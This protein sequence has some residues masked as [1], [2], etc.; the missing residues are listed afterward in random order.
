MRR[1]ALLTALAMAAPAL[2]QTGPLPPS[3]TDYVYAR[4]LALSA[5]RGLAGDN[6]AIFYNPAAIAG[7]RHLEIDLQGLLA[8][9][10]SD[11]TGT[12]FSFSAVDSTSGP[13]AGGVAYTYP[14]T[15]GYAPAGFFGGLSDLALAFPLGKTFY[16]GGTISYL[17]VAS[18]TVNVSA[19]NV[20][21]GVLWQVAKLVSVG[22]V[23]Y[24]LINTHHPDLTPLALGAGAAVGADKAF[25]LTGDFYREW[26]TSV[27]NVWS[28]GGEAFLF[29]VL[30][31]RGG[32]T[33]DL[34]RKTDWWAGGLGFYTGGFGFDAT[35]K[36]SLGGEGRVLAVGIKIVPNL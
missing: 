15:L 16:V 5:Y 13:V 31:V 6:D 17:A 26:G 28:A 22:A 29:D 21:P 32:W 11:T 34:G 20:T 36:Q 7:R 18:P 19:V 35:Y 33:F 12:F 27:R 2:A 23:G 8:R 24:N 10:G 30:A 25:H 3:P 1:L 14:K 9:D 4:S